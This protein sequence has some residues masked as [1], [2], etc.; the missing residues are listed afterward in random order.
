MSRP[1]VLALV[2][3]L[4][5]AAPAFAWEARIVTTDGRPV[6]GAVI[7]ILGRPGEAVTDDDGRFTWQPDPAPPFEILVIQSNGTYMKPVVVETL[8]EGLQTITVES[9]LSEAVT[10]TGSAP[11][12]ESTPAAGTTTLS[13]REVDVRQPTNLMQAIENVAGVNQVSEGQAAVPAVRGLARGRTLIII[14]GA[15]VT[16]ERRVGPSATYLDPTV[17]DSVDVARGPGSVA[18]GSDA[19]GG[20]ISI[21][22]RRVTPATPW[23]VRFQATAGTGIPDRRVSGMVSKGLPAGSVLFAA[24]TRS[25]DDWESPEGTVF[26]SGFADHGFLARVEQQ[27][28]RGMISVG[29]QSDFGRDI[30]RPRNNSRTVRFYYPYENSHRFTGAYELQDAG[31][32]RRVSVSTFLGSYDQRTDQDRFATATAGRSIERADVSAKDFGVRAFGEK[33]LGEA[34]LELGLDLNGRFGL[35]AIDDFITYGDDGT[36]ESTRPNVS[37]DNARRTDTGLYANLDTAL[38]SVLSLG[39]GVRADY[40]ITKNTG[41]YF[42][43]LSTTNGGASGYVA[44]T[45]GT[46]R[47]VSTTLQVAHGFRDPTLSDRYYRGPTGR[48]FITG[49]P[50]LD[51]ETSWQVDWTLRYTAARYRLAAFYYQYRINDLIERYQTTIDDFYFR[52]RGSARIRG[53]EVEGQADLG[54]GFTLDVA[55]QV[56]QGVALDTGSDL[57]DI[58][59]FNLTT[60]LRKAFGARAYTQARLAYFADDENE[61]PTEREVPGYTLL[62]AQ[63]GYTV[64]APLEIR[65]QAR[66]LLNETYLASQ[67]VRAV[68]AA[69]RSASVTI[70]VKF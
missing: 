32:F 50:D 24:H 16:S 13:G 30:E 46:F 66:N 5:L 40:V 57:D 20:V 58:S 10:V 35:E 69:G 70:A 45:A 29:W 12:I 4:F 68:L 38:T 3:V 52:N 65:V 23:A 36:I 61:G 48:G 31:F 49:N 7:S 33:L 26:N 60:V 55:T 27:V 18:Y 8:G 54:R 9:L 51:P 2:L 63:A 41:G 64:A 17:V 19:F 37:I 62:D 25:A 15:R 22:T 42:G 1:F 43:D 53:F 34:R 47:G 59:P 28:G 11:G 56:A 67:D 14:D 44:L 39:A 21:R 6:A